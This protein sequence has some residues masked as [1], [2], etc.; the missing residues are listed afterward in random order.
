MRTIVQCL[1]VLCLATASPFVCA[2]ITP[3]ATPNPIVLTPG[4]PIDDLQVLMATAAERPAT[5]TFQ[6]VGNGNGWL[7]YS[8][9]EYLQ[10][11]VNAP[12]TASYRVFA[13]VKANSGQ[14]FQLEDLTNGSSLGFTTAGVWDKL[15]IGQ[16]TLPAGTSALKLTRS[17]TI[18]GQVQLKSLELIRQSDY[19]AYQARVAAARADTTWLGQ[20]KYGLFFQ[21][22]SW[23]YPNNPGN[24]KSLDQQAQDFH[25]PSFVQLVKN[26][27]AKYVLWSFSWQSYQS[28]MPVSSIDTVIGNGSY[29]AQRNLIGELAAALKAQN[30]RFLIYYHSGDNDNGWWS[31]QNFPTTTFQ[32]RGTGDRSVFFTNWKAVITDIGNT[33]GPDLDGFFFDEGMIYYPAK[34]EELESIARTGN[35]NRLISWNP[36]V[37]PRFTD[38]QDVAFGEVAPEHGEVVAGSAPLGGNGIYV[39]GPHQGLLQHGMF[40]LESSGQWGIYARNQ[41]IPT[42]QANSNAQLID[43]V[44]SASSRG[45]PLS[46]NLSMYE[47]GTT[48]DADLGQLYALRNSIYGTSVMLPNWSHYNNTWAS[49]SYGGTWTHSAGRGSNDYQD[50]VQYTTVNGNSFTINFTGSGVVVYGPMSA[51]DG[52]GKVTLDG[53]DVATISAIN[54]PG[55][56]PQAHLIR[57]ANL[58]SGAHTLKITK[59]G[60]T[61][62]QL[63]YVDI[64]TP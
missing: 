18:S 1:F 40:I 52:T 12:A 38:F 51:D 62:L 37:M 26:T 28:D 29:T 6:G 55:Y 54:S 49:I 7:N 58:V 59:T 47:D 50:D 60:G 25:I 2:Q 13:L 9:S 39:S 5:A 23:G 21:Y 17:G 48:S 34:F 33:L 31:H 16:L 10:W 46:L 20:A 30:I 44:N 56:T 53:V 15:D 32:T 45:V 22:G 19:A 63:D 43:W 8:G 3:Q 61:Y 36:W 35:E 24:H 14:R 4:T 64:A 41:K 11:N 42:V 57:F 27:G